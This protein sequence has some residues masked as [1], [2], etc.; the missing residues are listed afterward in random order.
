M[1]IEET[2]KGILEIKEKTEKNKQIRI[3]QI[4]NRDDKQDEKLIL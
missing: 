1:S 2:R 4:E 3:K